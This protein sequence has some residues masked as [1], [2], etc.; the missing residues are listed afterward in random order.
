M[1]VLALDVSTKTGWALFDGAQLVSFGFL[2]KPRSFEECGNYPGNFT[3]VAEDMVN[4][5]AT[6]VATQK[7]DMLIVEET[8]KTGRFGS[9]HSQKILEFIHC[10]L[11]HRFKAHMPIKYINTSDWR[12]ILKLSVADT[13]KMA[14]PYIKELTRLKGEL[15]K[16]DKA[17]KKVAKDA[18]DAHKKTLKDKCIHGKI[19]KKSISVAFVNMTHK[20][21]LKKGDNDIS[22]AICLGE[23]YKRGV[24]TLTNKDI[25]DHE[26]K[27][28][29]QPSVGSI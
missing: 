24:K 11:I 2:E 5:I 3:Q 20:L 16:A 17:H 15:A 26:S 29:Q 23:A 25:F 18:L 14:K 6:V 8:N 9:R 13:K 27:A 7:P 28:I 12:K 19:D 1:K 4:L 21:A 10:F 22:D